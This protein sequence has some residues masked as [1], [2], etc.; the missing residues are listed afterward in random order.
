[1]KQNFFFSRRASFACAALLAA[2]ALASCNN[3]TTTPVGATPAA[4][5]AASTPPATAQVATFVVGP[6]VT[7]TDAAGNPVAGVQVNFDVTGG[8]AV[9]FPLATTDAQGLASSGTWQIGPKVGS[10]TASATVT[11][12]APV[13]FTV[14][15]QPGPASSFSISGGNN[16]KAAPGSTLPTPLSARIADAGGNGK[17][18]LAVT[19]AVTTTSTGGSLS[20][21]TATTDADGVA[22][23]GSWTLGTGQ[24]APQ[25]VVASSG[26]FNPLTFVAS[27]RGDVAVDGTATGA[28]AAGDCVIGGTLF[29][30]FDL[31]TAFGAVNVSITG[32]FG[33]VL[34]VITS[35]ASTFSATAG[36]SPMRLITAAG[37]KAVRATS[38]TAGE[39]GA[40]T[41]TVASTSSAVT[42]CSTPYIEVGVS[43]SQNLSPSDCTSNYKSVAGDGFLVYI[44]AGTSVRISET[45]QP[46]DA[47]FAFLSPSGTVI[48]ERD[49]GGVGPAGTEV[50]NY[51]ATVSGYY[52]IV[53]SSYC[54]VYDDT[55]QANC[56]YGPYT[57]S[58]I[59]Q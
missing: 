8:G 7:V 5:A 9:Q 47:L 29:D 4:V 34:Q 54:L 46:L 24:C 13:A 51:T 33:A 15:S 20:S 40:Y 31:P 19:F 41:V 35:D 6:A 26:T 52:K 57:L 16:Q 1:M 43:T 11:G 55:Y 39:T 27:T 18:G 22:T 17:P 2:A 44:A 10:N 50:F 23:S 53:A 58:V 14:A 38:A 48:T 32:G 59:K 36:A 12:L 21:T 45:A 56:D 28:L 25:T 37:N 30:E 3:D 49:R 42:D